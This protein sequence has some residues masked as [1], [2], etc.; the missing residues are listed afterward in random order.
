MIEKFSSFDEYQLAK[1]NKEKSQNKAKAV[2]FYPHMYEFLVSFF[3]RFSSSLGSCFQFLQIS[4]MVLFH[5][6]TK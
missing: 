3:I 2:T 5:S 4:F 1:Y 6:E